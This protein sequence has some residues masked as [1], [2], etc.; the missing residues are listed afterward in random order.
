MKN[1]KGHSH[2]YS[3]NILTFLKRNILIEG[4]KK[5]IKSSCPSVIFV[6][7]KVL[8]YL[9]NGG[10]TNKSKEEI[11]L[12]TIKMIDAAVKGGAIFANKEQKRPYIAVQKNYYTKELMKKIQNLSIQWYLMIYLKLSV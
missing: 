1:T 5:Y 4:K 9:P 3:G 12:T 7:L 2:I 6:A 11:Q 8:G 10:N